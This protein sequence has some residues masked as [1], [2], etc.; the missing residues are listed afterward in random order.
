MLVIYAEGYSV[1]DFLVGR[2]DRATFLNFVALGMRGNW[3]QAVS[4]HY[5][6]RDIAE[7][8]DRWMERVMAEVGGSQP[9][10]AER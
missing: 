4:K 8:Q 1:A 7:L 5:G 2:S 10:F 3:D 9:A 6:Y